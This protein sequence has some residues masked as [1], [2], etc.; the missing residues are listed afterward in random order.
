MATTPEFSELRE[1][2]DLEEAEREHRV[3]EPFFP[4]GEEV[5]LWRGRGGGRE[6]VRVDIANIAESNRWRIADYNNDNGLYT[7]EYLGEGNGK[8][9][10][11]EEQLKKYN[12]EREARIQQTMQQ[13]PG[14]AVH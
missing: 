8:M 5:R 1:P 6:D 2:V 3:K 13:P 11:T 12:P 14:D 10:V 9:E 4:V 7:V